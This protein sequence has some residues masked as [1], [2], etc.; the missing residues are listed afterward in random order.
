[1]IYK[2]SG[3]CTF[4]RQFPEISWD[5]NKLSDNP[6]IDLEFVKK[7]PNENWR[8]C[9]CGLSH[10]LNWTPKWFYEFPEKN[11]YWGQDGFSSNPNITMEFF[12]KFID[13]DW[14]W[15]D[16]GLSCNPAVTLKW[17]KK[18]PMGYQGVNPGT[19]S[20]SKNW[21]WGS[22]GLSS[23]PNIT[24]EWI[25]RYPE[26][27]WNWGS[28]GLSSNPNITFEWIL[29]FLHKKW[30]W[31]Y[32]FKSN[33]NAAKWH[34]KILWLLQN[35]E[36]TEKKYPYVDILALESLYDCVCHSIYRTTVNLRELSENPNITL[37]Q[38]QKKYEYKIGNWNWSEL[39]RNPSFQ[40]EWVN[41]FP[42][43]RWDWYWISRNPNITIEWINQFPTKKWDWYWI[44]KNPNVTI[45]WINRYPEKPWNWYWIAQNPNITIK[46]FKLFPLKLN[47]HGLSINKF[48]KQSELNKKNRLKNRFFIFSIDFLPMLIRKNIC[49]FI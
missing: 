34:K 42:T 45:E 16:Y 18:Y 7:H 24:I 49:M 19:C 46:W 4:M 29:K 12:E 47:N 36:F 26:K 22:F 20:W 17:L 31:G 15:G 33:I 8:W 9:E 25:E 39:S 40:I 5:Y 30:D 38:I 44:S 3:L 28:F 23:N 1:M 48:T 27:Q 32:L 13:K 21:V 2:Y 11:W 37:E 6:C 10:N 35:Q 43:K 41:Q 14:N